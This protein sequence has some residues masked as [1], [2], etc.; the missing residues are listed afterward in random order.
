MAGQR[1]H[2]GNWDEISA[3][4]VAHA[5]FDFRLEHWDANLVFG[6]ASGGDVTVTRY[7]N[8][9]GNDNYYATDA[10]VGWEA[11]TGARWYF[12]ET[13]TFRFYSG[14]GAALYEHIPDVSYS[15][16]S[17]VEFGLYGE[18]GAMVTFSSWSFGV[19][20]RM[21]Y[22]G[23]PIP[24]TP[25]SDILVTTSGFFVKFGTSFR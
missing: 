24:F 2:S 6:A 11:Y 17:S 14:F 25:D 9:W 23:S 13:R 16:D 5:E 4:D 8:S 18:V 21:L 19:G 3:Q 7:D 12:R 22:S 15:N 20:G 10:T 1:Y